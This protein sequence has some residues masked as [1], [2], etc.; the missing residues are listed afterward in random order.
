MTCKDRKVLNVKNQNKDN[1]NLPNRNALYLYVGVLTT[2][3]RQQQKHKKIFLNIKKFFKTFIK[4]IV[5]KLFLHLC[6]EHK[7][8]L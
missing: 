1:H 5:K 4:N 8:Y 3:T 6:L 2:K 7:Q